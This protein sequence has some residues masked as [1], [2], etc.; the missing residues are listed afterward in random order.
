[1]LACLGNLVEI[2]GHFLLVKQVYEHVAETH[3]IILAGGPIKLKLPFCGKDKISLEHLHLVALRAVLSIG[4]DE[5]FAEAEVYKSELRPIKHN[6]LWFKVFESSS[7][8]V[9]SL[10]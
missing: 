6:V 8:R 9:D 1:M 7:Y 10:Q 2:E 4:V 3:E 5:L